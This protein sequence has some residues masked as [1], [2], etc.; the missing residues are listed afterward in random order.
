MDVLIVTF[1][2]EVMRRKFMDD[3]LMEAL[4]VWEKTQERKVMIRKKGK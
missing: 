3:C 2:N 4:H 1:L